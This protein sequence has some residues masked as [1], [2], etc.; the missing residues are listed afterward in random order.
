MATKA[1]ERRVHRATVTS[2]GQVTLPKAL[3]DR[4]RLESGS[5]VEFVE[6]GETVTLQPARRRRR[7]FAEAIGTLEPPEGMTAEEYISDMR[8]EPGDREILQS[9]PGVKKITYI[10]DLLK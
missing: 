3:R 9:G 5:V 8:H 2:K 7:S 4:L 6:E 10:E 1:L